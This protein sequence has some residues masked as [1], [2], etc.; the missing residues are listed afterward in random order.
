MIEL[1]EVQTVAMADDTAP[2]RA[3][4]PRTQATYVLVPL[5]EFERLVGGEY[6]DSGWTR[7]ELH[8]QAWQAG[9]SIGWDAMD[10]YDAE[11]E[12]GK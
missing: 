9:H 10:E 3:V 4:D 2:T 5:A 11:P 7:E 1:T 12:A 8:A 6:D